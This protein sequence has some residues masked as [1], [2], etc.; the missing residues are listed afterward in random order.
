M[1][2]GEGRFRAEGEGREGGQDG[3][4]LGVLGARTDS[5]TPMVTT[6]C[7]VSPAASEFCPVPKAD[8]KLGLWAWERQNRPASEL[9]GPPLTLVRASPGAR[10]LGWNSASPLL[11]W[12]LAALR[13][14]WS[15]G[16]AWAGSVRRLQPP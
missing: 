9:R 7:R 10:Q 2:G 4:G 1:W 14:V 13:P 12:T 3:C 6:F 15:R 5:E 16:K 8:Q 11:T